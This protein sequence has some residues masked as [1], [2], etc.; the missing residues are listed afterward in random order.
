MEFM[1]VYKA[2]NE[3]GWLYDIVNKRRVL[4]DDV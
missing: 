2:A 4:N 3:A 1:V